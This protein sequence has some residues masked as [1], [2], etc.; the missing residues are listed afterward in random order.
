MCYHL[1][2]SAFLIKMDISS[3]KSRKKNYIDMSS[4][5]ER[6]MHVS[7]TCRQYN[8][9]AKIRERVDKNIGR[10]FN[11]SFVFQMKSVVVVTDL[12]IVHYKFDL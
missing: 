8:L 7:Y 10:D 12:E 1:N 6:Y 3:M 4:F 11:I 2:D 5:Q 9:L